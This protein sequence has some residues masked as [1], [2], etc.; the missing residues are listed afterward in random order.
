MT[1]SA[2]YVATNEYARLVGRVSTERLPP[3]RWMGPGIAGFPAAAIIA[4]VAV[5]GRLALAASG[6]EGD[7]ISG[8]ALHA[9]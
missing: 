7:L 1:T 6:G 3:R 2:D 8:R 5:A 9:R 4:L